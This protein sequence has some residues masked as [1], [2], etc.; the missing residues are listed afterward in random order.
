MRIDNVALVVEDTPPNRD[1]LE[2]LLIGA[3][4]K[5]L[6]AEGGQDALV[7][8]AGLETLALAVVDMQLSDMNGVQL[9]AELRRRYPEACLVIATMHD[10]H[11]LMESAF[12]KGCNVFLVKPHGFL[13][14]YKRLTSQ[15]IA[16]I[17]EGPQLVI[18]QYGPRPFKSAT[19]TYPK[20]G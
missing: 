6:G 18:D 7:Q 8:V 15:P 17:R 9:T 19:G 1:F 5:V 11:A 16:E 2:R 4:F 13:E 20:I 10:D 14:L 3:K 12:S